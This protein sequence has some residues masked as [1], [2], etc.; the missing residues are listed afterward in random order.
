[1]K[2]KDDIDLLFERL[3][4]TFDVNN[5]P[6]NHQKRFMERLNKTPEKT[7]RKFSWW[8]PLSIAATIAL[9][10][11]LVVTMDSHVVEEQGLAGIS[12][13]MEQTQSFFVTAIRQELETLKSFETEDTK[14]LIDDTIRRLELLEEEYDKLKTDL[15]KSGNDKRVISAMIENFQSRIEILEQVN[16]TIEEIKILKAHTN[17]TTL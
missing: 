10:I 16:Q 8:K 17:E 14:V 9:L 3:Q 7:N 4:G 12:P 15:E 6:E 1:M 13:E 11:G 5:T 2:Q